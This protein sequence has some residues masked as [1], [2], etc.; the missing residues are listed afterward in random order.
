MT[1]VNH[2]GKWVSDNVPVTG[3][4]SLGSLEHIDD[5]V[6][7]GN[8]INISELDRWG[9]FQSEKLRA[10]ESDGSLQPV[11]ITM[12]RKCDP[13]KVADYWILYGADFIASAS[14]DPSHLQGVWGFNEVSDWSKWDRDMGELAK[15]DDL[16]LTLRRF[17]QDQ[18]GMFVEATDEL[19]VQWRAEFDEL[20]YS[21]PDSYLIGAW[22]QD[23]QGKYEPGEVTDNHGYAAIVRYDSGVAQV[24]RSRWA[25]RAEL[26]SPCYPGQA[27]IDSNG[28]FMGYDFPDW[29]YGDRR[30]NRDAV[31]FHRVDE[32]GKFWQVIAPLINR[33]V[34]LDDNAITPAKPF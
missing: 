7:D 32:E 22:V 15:W 16:P 26:C 33:M 11:D 1:V 8:A 27:H 31:R 5:L 21:E 24:V 2:W 18:F 29:V 28:E 12:I 20:D 13:D 30:Q 6:H 10:A 23:D 25:I 34:G 3:V 9:E 14:D 17:C 4:V 19:I